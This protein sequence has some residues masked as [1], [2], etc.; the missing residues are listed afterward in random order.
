[1]VMSKAGSEVILKCLLGREDQ[2]DLDALPWGPEDEKN[3]LG[4]ETVVLADRVRHAPGRVLEEILIKREDH[5]SQEVVLDSVPDEDQRGGEDVVVI[6][7]E[8]GD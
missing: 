6:K 5:G 3:P 8:P 2:I 4:I 7:D 1:M